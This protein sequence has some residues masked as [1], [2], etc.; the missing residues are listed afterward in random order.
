MDETVSVLVFFFLLLFVVEAR[1]TS[2]KACEQFTCGELDFKF[3]FFRTDMPSRCGLFKLNCSENISEIQLVEDGKWYKIKS[4]SQAETITITDTELNQ[5]LITGNCRDLSSFFLPD[6]PWLSLTTLYKCNNTSMKNGFSYANCGGQG[7]SLYYSNLRN[8]HD[9]PGCSAINTP[10]S[11]VIPGKGNQYD[12]NA[13]FSLHIDLPHSCFDC[14]NRGG[15]C[16]I[17]EDKYQCLGVTQEQKSHEGIK[18]GL[19]VGITSSVLIC[20]GIFLYVKMKN[21]NRRKRFFERNGGLLLQQQLASKEGY[22]EKTIVF[23]STELEKATET[24]S[25]SRVLGHGGQ[26]TVYKGILADGRIVAV[27]KS[28]AVDEDKLDEFINEIVILSQINHR[29]IVRILGCCLETEV[30]LLVYEFIPNGNLFEL[31]HKECDDD[32]T[33]TTWE[34]RLRIAIDVAGALSYLHY[35]AASPIYHRDIKSTNIMLDENFRAKVS[36]FGTSR[37]ITIDQS[38]LTT[39]VSGTVGYVDPE[40]FQ[41]SQFTEK[42]DV[43]SFGVV[44]VE[45]ITGEKPVSFQRSEENRLL[46]TYFNLSMKDDRISDII[47]SRIRDNCK[48]EQVMMMAKLAKMCLNRKGKKRPNMREVWMQLERICLSRVD[49]NEDV[50]TIGNDEE[51]EAAQGNTCIESVNIDVTNLT[52]ST[53]RYNTN[54]ALWSDAEVLFPRQ[55]W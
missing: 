28:K 19:G 44:L 15:E 39:M 18:L 10:E 5:S 6:S 29:N 25:L 43:Y 37:S 14:Y 48:L 53:S 30:P 52:T 8:G 49:L 45:L 9:V 13:T 16:K 33:L 17:I 21:T 51:G 42:S 32:H 11:W 27:K 54:A 3:P 46:V 4:V 40:Y 55:T 26:G 24:F 20:G 22:V 41:S 2:R 35:A 38:H 36:D 12:V 31:L 1:R 50:P 34:A 7:S 47:D 23:R